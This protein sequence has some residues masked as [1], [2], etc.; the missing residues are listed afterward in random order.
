MGIS[1]ARRILLTPSSFPH[2]VEASHLAACRGSRV[3]FASYLAFHFAVKSIGGARDVDL[4]RA[5]VAREQSMFQTMIS[6]LLPISILSIVHC[7]ELSFRSPLASFVF[8]FSSSHPL[9]C[10]LSAGSSDIWYGYL[11]LWS[12]WTDG[13]CGT[14]VFVETAGFSS[15]GSVHFDCSSACGDRQTQVFQLTSRFL[16]KSRAGS[17]SDALLWTSQLAYIRTFRR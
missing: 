17:F 8:S 15:H 10:L 2:G 6:A 4:V 1:P 12:G 11:S 16:L 14:A 13:Y 7:C 9:A 3:C 5:T